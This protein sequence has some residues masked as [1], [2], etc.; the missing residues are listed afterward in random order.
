LASIED[1]SGIDYVEAIINGNPEGSATYDSY[2]QRAEY[3]QTV[4]NATR[5]ELNSYTF[6]ATDMN[7]NTDAETARSHNLTFEEKTSENTTEDPTENT[8]ENT[9]DWNI[10]ALRNAPVDQSFEYLSNLDAENISYSNDTAVANGSALY[11]TRKTRADH[12]DRLEIDMEAAGG[13]LEVVNATENETILVSRTLS[14]GSTT[15]DLSSLNTSKIR[16]K[17]SLDDTA[18]VTSLKLYGDQYSGGFF[19][20]GNLITGSFFGDVPVVG[21][22]L[23]GVTT[24]VNNVVSGILNVPSQIFEGILEVLPFQ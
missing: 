4:Q 7:G 11:E 21:N 22:V 16:L 12:F 15:V 3:V 14:T 17:L 23:S 6:E 1:S 18:T 20:G 5:Y 2:D 9:T 13:T 19:G 8:T 10:I 24:G